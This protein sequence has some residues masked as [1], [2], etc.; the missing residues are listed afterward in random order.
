MA[1]SL[2]DA[3]KK[4]SSKAVEVDHKA[5]FTNEQIEVLNR[6]VSEGIQSILTK[7]ENNPNVKHFGVIDYGYVE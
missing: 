5:K 1:M 3:R 6:F 2:E 7:I 4:H